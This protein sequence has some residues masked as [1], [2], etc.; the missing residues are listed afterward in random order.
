MLF[1]DQVLFC[2]K[3]DY[4][5]AGGFDQTMVVM[6]E[7]DFCLKMSSLGKEKMLHRCVYSSDRRV[8]EW[9]FWKANR[10][11]WYIAFGWLMGVENS[12]MGH[13]YEEIR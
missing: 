8:R 7:A 9:G 6:E 5:K 13:I 4:F 3:E 1:G 11:Y 12:K 10:I 2:R